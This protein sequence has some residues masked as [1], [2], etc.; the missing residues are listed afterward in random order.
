[1]IKSCSYVAR[2]YFIIFCSLDNN[3]V[4]SIMYNTSGLLYSSYCLLVSHF[5][6]CSA[7]HT[8]CSISTLRGYWLLIQVYG[9]L[10]QA[11]FFTNVTIAFMHNVH[12]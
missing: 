1:M 10:Q 11:L 2:E 9:R 7:I 5:L 3:L 6:V 12:R 4:V 8:H